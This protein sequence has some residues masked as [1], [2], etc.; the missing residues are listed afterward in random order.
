[1]LAEVGDITT[2]DQRRVSHQVLRTPQAMRSGVVNVLA[3]FDADQVGYFRDVKRAAVETRDNTGYKA[4]VSRVNDRYR[5]LES[6]V[7]VG[8]YPRYCP[9]SP[10]N[11]ARSLAGGEELQ[12]TGRIVT[13]ERCTHSIPWVIV[14]S[15]IQNSAIGQ[16]PAVAA[17]TI[18]NA[19]SQSFRSG[20]PT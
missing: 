7:D 4:E 19:E 12:E 15:A 3:I 1:M 17:G 18:L 13:N 8:R 16:N 2:G 11:H 6:F 10:R 5:G 20:D 9:K 14:G